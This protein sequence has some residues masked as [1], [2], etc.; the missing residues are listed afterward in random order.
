MVHFVHFLFPLSDKEKSKN[1][2]QFKDIRNTRHLIL[3]FWTKIGLACLPLFLKT[4]NQRIYLL[5]LKV[6]T[7]LIILFFYFSFYLINLS[8]SNK[9]PILF[10]SN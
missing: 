7:N 4:T 5:K 9:N 6:I 2:V 3:G 8:N 10:Q 1:F